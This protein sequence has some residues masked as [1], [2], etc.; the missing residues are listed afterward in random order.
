MKVVIPI[1]STLFIVIWIWV[2]GFFSFLSGN[3]PTQVIGDHRF[4][5]S[6]HGKLFFVSTGDLLLLIVPMIVA[7]VVLV[8]GI[9][10]DL[11]AR[12]Q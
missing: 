10:L 8:S 3:R 9:Y 12:R 4:E 1:F 5:L 11:R 6:N 7:A 2:V